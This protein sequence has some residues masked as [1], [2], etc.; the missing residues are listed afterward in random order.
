MNCPRPVSGVGPIPICFSEE[1]L[2]RLT[3]CSI[4]EWC[5]DLTAYPIPAG[6]R[7]ILLT[8]Q[9]TMFGVDIIP[10][11]CSDSWRMDFTWDFRQRKRFDQKPYKLPPP[12]PAHVPAETHKRPL[13][14]QSKPLSKKEKSDYHTHH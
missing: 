11:G 13:E 4:I 5:L 1:L 7:Y 14:Q 10:E 9:K 6:T 3:R 8:M 2:N 12:T